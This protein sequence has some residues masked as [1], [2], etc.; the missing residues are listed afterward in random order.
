MADLDSPVA[1]SS[2]R[3]NFSEDASGGFAIDRQGD[4][5][6]C[7]KWSISQFSRLTQKA[8]RCLW[9]KYFDVGGYD[10]RVLVYPAGLKQIWCA[11]LVLQI[12][13]VAY[14]HSLPLLRAETRRWRR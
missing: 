11:G 4:H 5:S 9:S 1:T 10:C 2:G 6:A 12:G 8:T 7:V 13:R 14:R 3:D